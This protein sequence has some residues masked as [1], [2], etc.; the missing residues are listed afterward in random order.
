MNTLETLALAL[1][2]EVN[3]QLNPQTLRLVL[4]PRY[5]ITEELR[6]A[7]KENRD[8]IICELLYKKAVA[9]LA[10]ITHGKPDTLRR[11]TIDEFERHT[12]NL[13]SP[14]IGIAGQESS[15]RSPEVVKAIVSN[16]CSR[17]REALVTAE[18]DRRLEETGI[19]Q[20]ERQVFRMARESI[21]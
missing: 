18:E 8:E 6:E 3:I 2:L 11:A 7:I 5:R 1:S 10:R 13:A 19:I 17:A 14:D 21:G 16:A 15:L 4:N 9:Y 12:V 20:S